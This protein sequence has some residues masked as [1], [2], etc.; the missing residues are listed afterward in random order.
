MTNTIKQNANKAVNSPVI[1]N[2]DSNVIKVSFSATSEQEKRKKA[3]Q[4]ITENVKK[5]YW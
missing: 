5:F 2:I 4:T 3:Q 1:K